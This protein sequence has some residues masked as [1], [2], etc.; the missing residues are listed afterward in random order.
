MFQRHLPSI[1]PQL[2]LRSIILPTG[3]SRSL[4][5]VGVPLCRVVRFGDSCQRIARALGA[6]ARI[7]YKSDDKM[8]I[9]RAAQRRRPPPASDY[10]FNY[11]T[12]GLVS[13][14]SSSVYSYKYIS[15]AR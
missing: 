8:R 4:E 2:I 6:P 3:T 11:F 15:S 13:V 7:Y 9:H 14:A 5:P 12:L 10:F 1:I